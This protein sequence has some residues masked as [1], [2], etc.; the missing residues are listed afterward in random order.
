MVAQNARSDLSGF[1]P[2]SPHPGGLARS[3]GLGSWVVARIAVCGLV[4]AIR[5]S[6]GA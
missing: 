3:R 2:L 5:A 6:G 4:G 1:N